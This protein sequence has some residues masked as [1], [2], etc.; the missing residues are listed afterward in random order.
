[1]KETMKLYEV[2]SRNAWK[3]V[4]ETIKLYTV[5]YLAPLL[6]NV[7][8]TIK[9]TIKLYEV[10]YRA[11]FGRLSRRLKLYEVAYRAPFGRLSRRLESCMR[12]PIAHRLEGPS[13]STNLACEVRAVLA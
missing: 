11:P 3:T 6:R 5:A 8:K 7:W 4:K 13:S 2:L 9:K 1:M 10:A 12:Q